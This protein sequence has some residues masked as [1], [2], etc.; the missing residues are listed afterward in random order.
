MRHRDYTEGVNSAETQHNIVAFVGNGFDLQVAKDYGMQIDTKFSSFYHY[1]KLRS[2]DEDNTIVRGMETLR[3]ESDENW[4]DVEEV[5]QQL[6]DTSAA[7]P[8]DLRSSL[9]SLQSKFSEFLNLAVPTSILEKLGQDSMDEGLA[10]SSLQEFLGDLKKRSYE[11]LEFPKRIYNYDLF[12]F[13]FV[14]FNYTPL[15]DDFIYLDQQQFDP[16]P[17]KTSGVDRNFKFHIDPLSGGKWKDSFSSY[18]VTETVHP[19]GYQSVPRS[20]LFGIDHPDSKLSNQD[21]ILRLSK[22]FWA[23]NNIKYSAIFKDT[24]LFIIFG[25]SLGKSDRWWWRSIAGSLQKGFEDGV[26]NHISPELIIYWYDPSSRPVTPG[27]IREKFLNFAN[28][29][30]SDKISQRIHVI[31]YNSDTRRKWLNTRIDKF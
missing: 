9:Q 25:C 17:Y 12:N 23:Q 28:D 15:L 26:G 3:S 13:L 2:F 19:H 24:E 14:N 5:V 16:L 11:N 8:S 1:L 7:S 21:P 4:S 10:I 30:D 6:L 31:V 29:F 20:L 18:V 22:P 27:K